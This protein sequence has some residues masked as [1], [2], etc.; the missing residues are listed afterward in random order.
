M[1]VSRPARIVISAAVLIGAVSCLK[2]M[3]SPPLDS[4]IRIINASNID[5]TITVDDKIALPDVAPGDVSALFMPAGVHT[6][7]YVTDGI[8]TVT[9]N[10]NATSL[11]VQDTYVYSPNS[12]SIGAVLLDTGSAVPA[13]KS[14]LR[15]LHLSKLAGNVDIWRTQ[16]DFAT[17]TKIQTPFPYLAASPFIQSDSGRWEVFTTAVGSST[18]VLSSGTIT[19]PGGG[20][21]TL[22]LLDVAGVATWRILP[23]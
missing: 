23:E 11:G 13:G 12:L 3:T 1:S 17:P 19:V 6:V 8:P 21:R 10:I 4:Q 16:P 5:L 2:G 9:L 14:K 22:V 18:K 7:G 15:V 20:R